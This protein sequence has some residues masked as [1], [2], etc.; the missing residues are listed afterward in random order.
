MNWTRWPVLKELY[1]FALRLSRSRES[2]EDLVQETFARVLARAGP[3]PLEIR[4][5]LFRTLRNLFVDGLRS[6]KHLGP[7][8]VP[9][10]LPEVPTPEQMVLESMLSEWVES[11][12]LELEFPLRETL[13]LR[14]VDGFSYA[15]I[16]EITGSPVNT[17]RSRLSRARSQLKGLIVAEP[18]VPEGCPLD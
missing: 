3:P 10:E 6:S 4:P 1:A 17:V 16:A 18:K 15:E 5:Y 8:R 2:A 9:A 11:A 13:W 14:E 7:M 12:L